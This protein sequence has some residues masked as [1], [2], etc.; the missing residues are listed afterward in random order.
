MKN[1]LFALFLML[2]L[3]CQSA[4]ASIPRLTFTEGHNG[5]ITISWAPYEWD[6]VN[7]Y[8]IYVS[9]DLLETH[10]TSD[11]SVKLNYQLQRGQ[12][13]SVVIG[14][15]LA[16]NGLFVEL[17]RGSYTYG[18]VSEGPCPKSIG[19]ATV[20]F[21]KVKSSSGAD[22]MML[23]FEHV[24]TNLGTAHQGFRVTV[25]EE[26]ISGS[27]ISE[28][29]CSA[30]GHISIRIGNHPGKKIYI[31]MEAENCPQ[32]IGTFGGHYLWGYL[33]LNYTAYRTISLEE[34]NT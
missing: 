33:D 17:T 6:D 34:V 29:H 12:C 10:Y 23:T 18:N 1:Y 32:G 21:E 13:I 7:Y 20:T 28:T 25:R 5:I 8:S 3:F 11:L 31:K 16:D 2:P 27:T 4:K 30:N 24:G 22:D 14:A 15:T 26:S 9:G 19:S